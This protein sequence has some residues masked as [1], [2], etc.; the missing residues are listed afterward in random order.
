MV[1][2]FVDAL[3]ELG[4]PPYH[5]FFDKVF[6]SI[7]PMP[8]LRGK[9]VK[10]IGT[11]C[12][13]RTERCPLKDPK[14]QGNKRKGSFDSKVDESEEIIVCCWRISRV[15]NICSNAVG[16]EPV[17]QTSRHPGAAKA[18]AQVHQP[19]LG[20]LYQE[21]A[22]GVDRMDQ[23]IAKDK[24][25][26]RSM[27]WDFTSCI[28]DAALNNAWQLHR[29]CCQDAQVDLLAFHRS[30]ARPRVS[31]EQCRHF[32]PGEAEPAGGNREPLQYDWA[33]DCPSGQEDP[34]CPLLLTDQHRL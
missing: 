14:E 6:T 20:K 21:K 4:S 13:Y 33:L 11:V 8:I 16:T 29:V 17:R 24:V 10:V 9:G 15:V 27:K 25:Q 30:V 5:I 28:I 26:I 2:R 19:S 1:V 18:G 12:E 3:Q 23:N 34:V 31:G 32:L 7:N 22:R